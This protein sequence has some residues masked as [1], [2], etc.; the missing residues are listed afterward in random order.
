[1]Y[2]V[3]YFCPILTKFGVFR[4]VFI[5]V[6][7]IKFQRSPS[8]DSRADTCGQTD[9]TK[10]IVPTLPTRLIMNASNN[11]CVANDNYCLLGCDAVVSGT[12]T[13]TFRRNLLNPSSRTY[14]RLI[15]ETSVHIYQTSCNDTADVTAMRS[16]N[17]TTCS[18][19]SSASVLDK[20]LDCR[21]L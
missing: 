8:S 7:S 18:N 13:L 4:Q 10:L 19:V 15:S 2:S 12:H 16:S 17:L 6:P 3:R 5:K 1:M 9:M 20:E 14:R 21:L 11:E